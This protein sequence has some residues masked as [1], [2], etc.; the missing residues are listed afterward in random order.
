MGT[1]ELAWADGAV[2]ADADRQGSDSHAPARR[3]AST[4]SQPELVLVPLEETEP[5]RRSLAEISAKIRVEPRSRWAKWTKRSVDVMGSALGLTVLSPLFVALGCAAKCGSPGPIFFVQERC[6]LGGSRF[7]FYKFRTMV[8]DAEARKAGLASLNEM[9][10][11]VFKIKLDPRINRV[12][13]WMRKYSLD[14]LPQLWNVL[15][16]D[17]SLV[18]PRPPTVEEVEQ[19]TPDQAQ[20]LG[21]MPGITGL[22]QVSGRSDIPDFEKWIE[23]DL[24]YARAWS[25]LLDARILAKTVLVVALARGAE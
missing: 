10:G 15:K 21:V 13:R 20:R 16:G 7:R 14:E 4:R 5:R 18:G 8:A 11:P 6:G 25:I 9:R 2:R 24:E 12:G 23:L 19:Y 3:E 1:G 17:M 22:W